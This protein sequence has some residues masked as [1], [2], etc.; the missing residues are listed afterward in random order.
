M[1]SDDSICCLAMGRRKMVCGWLLLMTEYPET[2]PIV[3][4]N[5]DEISSNSR[6][7]LTLLAMLPLS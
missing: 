2:I 5:V 6:C 4:I 7:H 3:V 1:I